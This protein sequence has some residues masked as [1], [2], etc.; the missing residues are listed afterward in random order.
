[1]AIEHKFCEFDKFYRTIIENTSKRKYREGGGA[2]TNE[3]LS[4]VLCEDKSLFCV[5]M[6]KWW[7]SNTVCVSL[8]SSTGWKVKMIKTLMRLMAPVF[9]SFNFFLGRGISIQAIKHSLCY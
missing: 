8:T 5:V 1:M 3:H 4:C 9:E 2:T 7:P 6:D